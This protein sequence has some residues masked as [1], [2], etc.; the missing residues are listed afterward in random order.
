MWK[1]RKRVTEKKQSF[2]LLEILVA[3]AIFALA[4]V[5][6]LTMNW[7]ILGGEAE[8]KNQFRQEL[9]LKHGAILTVQALYTGQYGAKLLEEGVP[10]PTFNGHMLLEEGV[11]TLSYTLPKGKIREFSIALPKRKG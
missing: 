3:M 2:F 11:V 5:P 9:E 1:E 7:S 8:E 6:L 4:I 10:L